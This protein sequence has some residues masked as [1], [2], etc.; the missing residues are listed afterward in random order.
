MITL[1]AALEFQLPDDLVP[2]EPPEA[3]GLA[4][5]EVRLMV[6]RLRD[7]HIAHTRF[8]HL[9]DFLAS[10]DVL[11]INT[12]ATINAALEAVREARDRS[13]SAVVLHLSTPL[14]EDGRHWVVEL[15]RRSPAGT[16]PLL[17][18]EPGEH[19]RL[20]VGGMARLVEP[21]LASETE[22]SNGRTRLWIAELTLPEST[23][24]YA[25][26]YGSPIRYA[27]APRQWPLEYYQNV[28]ANEPGS[29]EMPSAGRPFT[30]AMLDTLTRKGVHIAPLVLH[31]GVSSLDADEHPYP[32]RYRVPPDTALAVNV[33]RSQGGR[34]VAVGT[35]VV[36]ALETVAGNDGRIHSDHGWTD[37]VITPERGLRAV[38]AILTGLHGPKASH[39]SLLEALA[40][41]DHLALAYKTALERRY[42]WHEFGDLHLIVP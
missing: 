31:S 15:R 9:P 20:P 27:Y 2:H 34:I 4:R 11:V 23:L 41:R 13:M 37:L 42:L 24:A 3:R 32:E 8:S 40:C 36:R 33:T 5:D 12:S 10:G 19:I 38:D 28:F 35:T 16:S 6:S 30:H 39:L 29:A 22:F 21:Y 25:A 14:S 7:N 18:A 26:H 1:D 17:D